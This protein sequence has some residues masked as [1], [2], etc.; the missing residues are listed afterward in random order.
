[1]SGRLRAL[2]DEAL[3]EVACRMLRGRSP[4][5]PSP[6]LGALVVGVL[7]RAQQRTGMRV[8]AFVQLASHGH[9]LLRPSGVEQLALFMA[10][11][12]TSIAREHGRLRG[13][14][15]RRG[16]ASDVILGHEARAEERRLGFLLVEAIKAWRVASPREWLGASSLPALASGGTL[17]GVWVHRSARRGAGLARGLRSSKRCARREVLK[18]S[19]LPSWDALTSAQRRS[20]ARRLIRQIEEEVDHLFLAAL[21]RE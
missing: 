16:R 5:R 18:L 1:M 4:L 7:A 19:P 2:P 9:L 21:S 15:S 10:Y 3:I 17:R 12:D 8:C 13:E 11:V 14:R 20:R 6:R